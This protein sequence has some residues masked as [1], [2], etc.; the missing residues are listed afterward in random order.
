MTVSWTIE[1]AFEAGDRAT[2]VP[3]LAQLYAKM[4][5]HPV[6]VDLPDLWKRLGVSRADGRIVYDDAAPLA[7]VRRGI[8]TGR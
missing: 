7:A 3:V 4:G 2:G 6:S 8:T 5:D 1:K